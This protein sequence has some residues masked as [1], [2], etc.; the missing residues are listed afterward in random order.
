VTPRG[1]GSS[2]NVRDHILHSSIQWVLGA[3][4][5]G[6]ERPGREADH[7]PPSSVEVKMRSAIPPLPNTPL[8]CGAQIR[9]TEKTLYFTNKVA[10]LL[11]HI[12]V[13]V[14]GSTRDD[15]NC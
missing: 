9:S 11:F 4:S 7:S 6:V 15:K 13:C 5:L 14:Q 10:T 12:C 8:W 1:S 3:L 2:F